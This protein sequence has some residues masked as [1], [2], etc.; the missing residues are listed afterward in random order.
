MKAIKIGSMLVE[1]EERFKKVVEMGTR[2]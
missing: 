1:E 2:W